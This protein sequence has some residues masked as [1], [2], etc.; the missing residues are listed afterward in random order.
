MLDVMTANRDKRVWAVANGKELS[1]DDGNV[2]QPVPVVSNVGGG[3]KSSSAEK[4]GTLN[5][6]SGEEGLK[7]MAVAKGFEMSLFA[8]ESRF[9]R[10]AN[11]VQLQFDTKGRLWAAVWPSYPN[12]EPTRELKDALVIL[13]DDNQD[14]KA[15]RLT[16]FAR[17]QNPLGFEFWNGGVIVNCARKSCS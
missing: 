8:D 10:L 7:H 4:E 3:S 11:P 6:I 1:I 15:D 5:Y 13:H 17:V 9:P 2:P 16:E 12:W 14:G